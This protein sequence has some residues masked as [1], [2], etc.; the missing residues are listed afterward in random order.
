MTYAAYET[1]ASDGYPI[2][3]YIFRA[4][5]NEWH[6]TDADEDKVISG[7]TYSHVP[8]K[9]SKV[10]S[11]QDSAR[12]PITLN[13][14][15]FDSF[16]G[17]FTPGIVTETVSVTIMRYHEG[18]GNLI[19]YWKGR[20]I[21]SKFDE[22]T[23]ELKCDPISTSMKGLIMRQR[24]QLPCPHALYFVGQGLCNKDMVSMRVS[25]SV[26]SISGNLVT[27]L[28][29]G[30]F[31]NTWFPGGLVEWSIG[32]YN[33]KRFIVSQ[34][35]NVLELDQVGTN[36]TV[37]QA[38]FLYPGCDH[39]ITTCHNK[40]NNSDNYGGQI[41]YSGKNPFKDQIF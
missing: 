40:F 10:E 36:L 18:D 19:T 1:S 34:N 14:S 26:V 5:T 7:T 8:M 25:L 11:T 22:T 35:I 33:M 20:V 29:A 2:E 23:L 37:G 32:G 17:F 3:Y 6:R 13:I 28:G 31:D 16:C 24:Y 9:R 4:G 15:T 38:C 39:T 12:Q 21:S 41:T 30:L 27:F